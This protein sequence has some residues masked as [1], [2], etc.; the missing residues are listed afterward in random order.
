MKVLRI[1]L[2]I[3]AVTV[4]V[5]PT[6]VTAQRA[7]RP[8]WPKNFGVFTATS[9]ETIP[10][11]PRA[12][13]GYRPMRNGFNYWNEP[14]ELTGSIRVGD[15]WDG[16]YKFPVTMNHC[17]DGVFTIRWRASNPDVRIAS[18]LASEDINLN[19]MADNSVKIGRFG[20]MYGFNCTQPAFKFSRTVN[21]NTSNIEDIYY[22]IKFWR[23]AP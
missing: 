5:L 8:V 17:S 13:S 9:S 12:L 7:R 1:L 6:A 19:Y 11:F 16:I 22:E 20:Y 21:G 18:M 10:L 4:S 15:Q 14:F 2:V 3:S 23:A